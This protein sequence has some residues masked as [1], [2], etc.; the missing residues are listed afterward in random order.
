MKGYKYQIKVGSLDRKVDIVSISNS[1]DDYGAN[2]ETETITSHW[3]N[4]KWLNSEEDESS[5]D[6]RANYKIDVLI[7][8]KSGVTSLSKVIYEGNRYDIQGYK[9]IGRKGFLLLSCL[10][11]G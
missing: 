7:R 9:E 8:Y 3:A 4:I 5:G 1:T 2:I 10:S 6:K 11:Y